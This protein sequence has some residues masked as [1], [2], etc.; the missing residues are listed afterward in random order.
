MQIAEDYRQALTS[1]VG[2][3]LELVRDV[4]ETQL[5]LPTPCENWSV[6]DVARHV[7]VT[8][9]SLALNLS[10]H[11]RGDPAPVV[12]RLDANADRGSVVQS[13]SDGLQ[14]MREALASLTDETLDG[15]LPSPVG[16]IPA[17]T[18]L[19]LALTELVLHRC[20]IELAVNGRADI[21]SDIAASIIE[22]LH[23]WLLLVSSGAPKPDGPLCYRFSDGS[24][25][26]SFNFDGTGWGG[27]ACSSESVVSAEGPTDQLVLALAGRITV[28]DAVSTTSD[29]EGLQRLKTYLPGP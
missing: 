16:L 12:N 19:D 23:A 10:A 11:F 4:D 5:A 6:L 28:E 2:R 8:P 3:L 9:R 20:D 15:N 13:L 17:R 22:V 21:D 26:W 18:A 27:D 29:P 24:R 14:L 1:E 7:E 25:T